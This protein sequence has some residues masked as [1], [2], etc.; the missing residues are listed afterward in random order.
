MRT[1]RLGIGLSF[2]SYA[3]FAVS[4]ASVK[5]IKGGLPPYESAFFG[6]LFGL[7]VLPLLKRPGDRWTDI[8]TTVNRPLWLLRFIAYPAGVIGS[9]TAF[10]HLSMAEAFVLIFLQPAYITIL[11]VVF[12]H[13]RSTWARW[14]AVIT[15]FVGVLIVLRPGFRELSIGHLGAL[16]GGLSGAIS[17]ICF[18]A[19]GGREK[20]LSQY[21]AGVTGALIVCGALMFGHFVPPT[22]AQWAMLA[23]YGVLAGVAILVSMAATR[24]APAATLGPT[25]YSQMLWAI[26]FGYL[27]FGDKLDLFMAVGCVFIIGSG[28]LT[29]LTGRSTR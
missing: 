18:R 20:R 29:V 27:L 2:L 11:A 4:D 8:F 19:L 26:A 12:L 22:L 16:F 25:Q 13:E 28:L 15:G 7:A 3:L 5:L 9:V 14:A 1:I 6:A 10:T 24:R 21:G 17:M 23:S